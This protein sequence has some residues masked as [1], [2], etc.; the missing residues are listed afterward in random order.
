MAEK[1]VIITYDTLF[2]LARREKFRAELQ[3]VDDKFFDDVIKYFSEKQSIIASQEKNTSV[4]ASSELEK[5][6]NQLREAKRLL[7]E[8]YTWRETKIVQGAIFQSR[9]NGKGFDF[10]ALLPEEVLM[11]NSLQSTLIGF[12]EK[13]L[14]SLLNHQ[15]PDLEM[16]AKGPDDECEE[17][18]SSAEEAPDTE[19]KAS[20]AEAP[21]LSPAAP[22]GLKTPSDTQKGSCSILIKSQLPEFMGP[23]M[24]KYGPYKE[25]EKA[26]L[27]KEVAEMLAKSGNA[28]KE[29]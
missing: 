4:F 25:G 29:E 22:K 26:E 18:E 8:I 10:S 15:K 11:F 14:H 9:C 5:T 23:D 7:K 21:D 12:K 3:K 20:A 6:R 16:K 19:A 27:P 17:A 1:E 24:K 28:V 2:D 13:I